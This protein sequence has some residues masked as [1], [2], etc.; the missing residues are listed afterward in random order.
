MKTF[1]RLLAALLCLALPAG[2]LTTCRQAADSTTPSITDSSASTDITPPETAYDPALYVVI[3]SAEDLMAFNRA[4]N[5][6]EYDFAGMTVIFLADLD[7]TDYTWH[8]LNGHCLSNVTFDGEGHTLRGLRLP[9]HEVVDA[10]MTGCGFVGVTTEDITFR[11]LTL[12]DTR[13]T[14]YD[15]SVGNFIGAVRGGTATF[16]G[17]RSLDFSA[18]G[19]M[20][21]LNRDTATGGH[22]TASRLGGFV[23]YIGEN[24]AARFTDCAAENLTLRG[25]H[26]LAGFVGYDGSG[27]LTAQDFTRCT[28]RKAT[29]T[30]S[31]PLAEGF[32]THQPQ[33]FVAVFYNA[34]DWQ[35]T[36]AP[37]TNAG[38]TY[39]QITYCD[40]ANDGATYTPEHFRS[41]AGE[42]E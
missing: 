30:F 28:V 4:V 13:V 24:G 41:D 40:W 14:A 18:E 39:E 34:A 29:L 26:N 11:N 7:M 31:Y 27:T 42:E 25:F 32:D 21:W 5:V 19:W 35:D 10:P 38:N 17:C 36:L 33:K 6:D 1:H 23:G 20:D 8:P 3:R 2:A 16:E 22:T 12:E 9:D 37:C 15:H